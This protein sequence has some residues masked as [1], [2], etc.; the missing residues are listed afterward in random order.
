MEEMNE[1]EKSHINRRPENISSWDRCIGS[2]FRS[3]D[4][5]SSAQSRTETSSSPKDCQAKNL[6]RVPH[7]KVQAGKHFLDMWQCDRNNISPSTFHVS[8]SMI[9]F[10]TMHSHVRIHTEKEKE[11][12]LPFRCINLT[13]PTA[14]Q[15]INILFSLEH[16]F[17]NAN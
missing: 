5:V 7:Y 4:S 17:K 13:V 15:G 1:K 2:F 14:E 16:V 11:S 3:L 9:Y 6:L 10:L 12:E 8:G